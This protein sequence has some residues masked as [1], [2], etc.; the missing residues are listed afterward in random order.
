MI[1]LT[2]EST[3][4]SHT[5]IEAIKQLNAVKSTDLSQKNIV[6]SNQLVNPSITVSFQQNKH[7][8]E[9]KVNTHFNRNTESSNLNIEDIIILRVREQEI[10]AAFLEIKRK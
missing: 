2:F 4:F 9:V 6:V 1:S 7:I 3:D 8:A 5:N 10:R